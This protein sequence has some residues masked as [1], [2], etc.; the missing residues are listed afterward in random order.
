MGG[1]LMKSV[2]IL[3]GGNSAEHLVSCMSAKEIRENIDTDRFLVSMAGISKEN[4]WY[5]YNDDLSILAKG[6][7][8]E[9]EKIVLI[10]NIVEYLK[11]F[12]V[13]FPI[14][15]GCQGEDGKLQGLFGFLVVPLRLIRVILRFY[16][17]IM[18]FRKRTMLCFTKGNLIKILRCFVKRG[19]VIL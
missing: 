9:A 8:L 11:G 17:I 12:D 5:E 3:F 10:D 15:H 1:N 6:E 2:L 19:L 7:W 18:I 14:I 13:V 4:V 16:V